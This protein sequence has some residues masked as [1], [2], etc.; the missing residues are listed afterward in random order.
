MARPKDGYFIDKQ[1]VPGV[2]TIISRFKESGALIHWAWQQGKDG[3]DFRETRDA[4]ADAGTLAHDMVEA[5]YFGVELD[6]SSYKP[7]TVTA[8]RGAFAAYLEWKAQ[9]KLEV[10]ESEVSLLSKVHQFGGTLDCLLIQNKRCLADVKTSGAVYSDH[11]LQLAAYAILWTENFPDQPIDGGYYI[12]RFGRQDHPNDPVRFAVHYYS[13]LGPSK[14]L[15]L[16]YRAAYDLDK[17][18]RKLV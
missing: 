18:L 11:L 13:D 15:F 7:D 17:R 3:K 5:D 10:C 4:A 8:A 2:T 1:R 12:L 9:T 6:L 14:E 16:A